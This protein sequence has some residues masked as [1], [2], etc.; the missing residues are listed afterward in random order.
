MSVITTMPTLYEALERTVHAYGGCVYVPPA[1]ISVRDARQR[2]APEDTV[3]NTKTN[4]RAQVE[5]AWY[6]YTVVAG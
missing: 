2:L 1:Q 6:D 3:K 5:D 4:H